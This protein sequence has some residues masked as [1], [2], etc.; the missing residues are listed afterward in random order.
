MKKQEPF[1]YEDA[2]K[3]L[4]ISVSSLH[5]WKASGFIRHVRKG[6]NGVRFTQAEIDRVNAGLPIEGES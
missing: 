1:N 4:G 6:K 2:A 5:N 3:L